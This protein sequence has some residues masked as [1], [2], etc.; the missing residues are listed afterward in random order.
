MSEHGDAGA[1]LD[2][3]DELRRKAEPTLSVAG[4]AGGTIVGCIFGRG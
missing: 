2:E 4:C 3:I 1:V